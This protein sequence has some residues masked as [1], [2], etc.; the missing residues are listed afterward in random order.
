M[1]TTTTRI[2]PACQKPATLEGA[3][4][5][6]YCGQS[7]SAPQHQPLPKGALDAIT[8][9]SQ[10][11]NPKAKLDILTNAE[12]EYPDCLE[13][14]E[15]LLFLGRLHERD[16]KNAD[17]SVIKCYLYQLYLTPE[18]FSNAKAEA[19]R[20]EFF[21]HPQLERCLALAA[22]AGTFTKRYLTRLAG[23]FIDLFLRGSNVYMRSIFG[24]TMDSKA[25]QLLAAPANHILLNI[26]SD[27]ALPQD[28]RHTLYAAFY[29][30]FD[31]Q[32]SGET[33]WLDE[34]LSK[35]GYPIPQKS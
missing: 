18:D 5:C 22:D 7:L 15:E 14:A 34:L 1:S 26:H 27:L 4:F 23:E 25:P 17:Y 24:F 21:S 28:Q 12:K 16:A 33:S 29:N 10:A 6:P 32:M 19:M 3:T 13:I 35:D 20:T 9:A 2:C 8:K 11:K 31:R 30:A